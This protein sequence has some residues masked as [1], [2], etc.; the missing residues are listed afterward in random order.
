MQMPRGREVAMYG[1]LIDSREDFVDMRFVRL[2]TFEVN[3]DEIKEALPEHCELTIAEWS[4]DR[5]ASQ[6]SKYWS[7]VSEIA[8]LA[9]QPRSAVHNLLLNEYGEIAKDENGE[10]ITVVMR[11][12][13]NY[14]TDPD[15]HLMPTGHSFEKDGK[16]YDIYVKL[17]DSKNLTRKQFSVL[18]DAAKETL[19][20]LKNG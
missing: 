5:N 14:L 18:I 13:Y 8:R 3:P 4:P 19:E 16:R 2:L 20:E 15:L 9:Q 7:I 6:N 1:R 10:P 12:S 11:E 17:V